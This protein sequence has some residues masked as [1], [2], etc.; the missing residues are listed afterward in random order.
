MFRC[1]SELHYVM[2]P[3]WYHCVAVKSPESLL[4]ENLR[5]WIHADT[6]AAS[7]NE[8]LLATKSSPRLQKNDFLITIS[9]QE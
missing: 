1:E 3:R 8:E 7:M 5:Y 9:H 6:E 2:A 4:E